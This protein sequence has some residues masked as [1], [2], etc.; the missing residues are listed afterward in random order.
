MGLRRSLLCELQSTKEVL[1]SSLNKVHHLE[2]ESRKV[3]VLQQK[4]QELERRVASR[5]SDIKAGVH[6][7]GSGVRPLSTIDSG[8]YSTDSTDSDQEQD[9]SKEQGK[10]QDRNLAPKGFVFEDKDTQLL[11][12]L[13]PTK[14]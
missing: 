3:P 8:L 6:V 10:S 2:I 13:K 14:L 4:V 1:I 5:K 12:S 7:G 9:K 11:N